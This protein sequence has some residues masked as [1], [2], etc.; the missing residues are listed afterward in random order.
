MVQI[1]KPV[2]IMSQRPRVWSSTK[3]LEIVVFASSTTGN[4]K[5]PDTVVDHGILGFGYVMV[6]FVTQPMLQQPRLPLGEFLFYVCYKVYI[7]SMH[8]QQ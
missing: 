8:E 4:G 2:V 3:S 5:D 6:R 1:A 7:F